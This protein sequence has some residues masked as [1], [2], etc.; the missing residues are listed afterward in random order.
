MPPALHSSGLRYVWADSR[1]PNDLFLPELPEAIIAAL[2]RR[3]EAKAAPIMLPTLTVDIA[4]ASA[5]TRRFLNGHQAN[6][7]QWNERLF[8]A[9]CDLN[10]RGM[11]ID[12]ARP[13]LLAGARPWNSDEET[14]ALQTIE[15]GYSQPR[16]PS[17]Y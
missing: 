1:S 17:R 10:G 15:S 5:S 14:R 9:A 8:K 11:S 13:L 6:G 2:N 4:D 7:P 16:E 3:A 12:D